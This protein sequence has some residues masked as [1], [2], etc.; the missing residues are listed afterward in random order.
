MNDYEVLKKLYNELQKEFDRVFAKLYLANEE[1]KQ[2]TKENKKLEK[3][4]VELND[5][6]LELKRGD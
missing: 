4:I 6:I 3:K 1:N 5:K 2:L